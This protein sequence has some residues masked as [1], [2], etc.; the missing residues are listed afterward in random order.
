MFFVIGE[1]VGYPSSTPG[2][3]VSVYLKVDHCKSK[4]LANLIYNFVEIIRLS[5]SNYD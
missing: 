2:G 1:A 3:R 5:S 4:L